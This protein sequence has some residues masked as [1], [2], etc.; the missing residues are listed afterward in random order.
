[1]AVLDAEQEAPARTI[2]EA[3]ERA[4]NVAPVRGGASPDA[5]RLPL[6]VLAFEV[7]A[8]LSVFVWRD[9]GSSRGEQPPVVVSMSTKVG[10]G[11]LG[12]RL[13]FADGL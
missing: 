5:Q 12:L 13:H 4:R 11:R 7:H 10:R 1:M 9:R 3:Y 6:G 2:G 8:A